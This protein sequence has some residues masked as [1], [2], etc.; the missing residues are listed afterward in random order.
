MYFGFHDARH[1]YMPLSSE[2]TYR[3]PGTPEDENVAN[4]KAPRVYQRMY[5]YVFSLRI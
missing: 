3:N 1:F 4:T 2:N 5:S